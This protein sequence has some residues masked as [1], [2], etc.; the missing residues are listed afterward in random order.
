[1]AYGLMRAH[2]SRTVSGL[3]AAGEQIGDH[4]GAECHYH[5]CGSMKEEDNDSE[6]KV[7]G[8]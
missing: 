8:A 4:V 3:V 1:M 6:T 2:N 5:N 7:V